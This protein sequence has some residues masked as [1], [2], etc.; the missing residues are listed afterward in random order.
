MIAF[1][2]G[3]TKLGI[4]RRHKFILILEVGNGGVV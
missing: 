3:E 2:E 4:Y 1:R